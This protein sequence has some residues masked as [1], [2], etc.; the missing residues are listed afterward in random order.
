MFWLCN[1]QI[2]SA[3]SW[4]YDRKGN[5]YLSVFSRNVE[6]YGPEKLR[7]RTFFTQCFLLSAISI[8]VKISCY[9][10]M[11]S[12]WFKDKA[13]F[14]FCDKLLLI[15][16]SDFWISF[17]IVTC[18]RKGPQHCLNSG[19]FLLFEVFESFQNLGIDFRINLNICFWPIINTS[20]ETLL[21]LLK[22]SKNIKQIWSMLLQYRYTRCIAWHIPVAAETFI[23]QK[24]GGPELYG[25]K[26]VLCHVLKT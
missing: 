11:I 21:F 12:W 5:V 17:K 19:Y 4:R 2:L 13:C 15:N 26:K 10:L 3:W 22:F 25:S 14:R 23:V 1:I 16:Y 9:I 6:K 7:I 18:Q 24:W 20:D 8:W